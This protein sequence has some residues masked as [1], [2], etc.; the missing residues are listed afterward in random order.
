M[1]QIGNQGVWNAR[2]DLDPFAFDPWQATQVETAMMPLAQ[3]ASYQPAVEPS[4]LSDMSSQSQGTS[5]NRSDDVQFTHDL[6]AHQF[7]L[8]SPEM[9]SSPRLTTPGPPSLPDALDIA[10]IFFE[11]FHNY[12]PLFHKE[13]LLKRLREGGVDGVPRVLLLGL[14]S[15]TAKSHH[16]T[17]IKNLQEQWYTQCKEEVSR[18]M[19]ESQHALE[20]LQAAVLLIFVASVKAEF[21][22]AFIVLAE[23]WRKAVAIGYGQ[24]DGKG[25]VSMPALGS[26]SPSNWIE[27]EE[28]RR[29]A[30]L[31]FI[32]DRGLCFPIGVVHNIDD[33]RL[34]LR[35]PLV[36][37]EFQRNTQSTETAPPVQYCRTLSKLI[38]DVQQ[39]GR[40]D[41]TSLF[42]YITLAYIILGRLSEELYSLD[43]DYSGHIELLNSVSEHLVRI[44]LVTPLWATDLS[45][46]EYND[47]PSVV[48]LRVVMSVNTILVHHRPVLEGETLETSQNM[49][50]HWPHCLSAARGVANLLR[51]AARA[52]V[53][54]SAN[55]HM[56]T[57]LFTCYYVLVIEYLC[58]TS[59]RKV[60]SKTSSGRDA[61]LKADLEVLVTT[62]AKFQQS[63][64]WLGAKYRKGLLFYLSQDDDYIRRCKSNGARY[65]LSTCEHW[66][67]ELPADDI[68]IPD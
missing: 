67:A 35:F 62:F 20:T 54:F 4:N 55:A 25:K 34:A 24:I 8:P 44:A 45:A 5:V 16:S 50:A 39:S 22:V 48:W 46:A 60:S 58:P 31:L 43:F 17:H 33:R 1:I 56:A 13:S 29:V 59:G 32:Y 12:L 30:W 2:V 9:S 23:A 10:E 15:V 49:A 14:L 7:G 18:M 19:R 51:D 66:P 26:T 64:G 57:S 52:S 47:M 65:L 27:R 36:E 42:T 6:G 38:T 21:P 63:L 37:D 28:A 53:N 3:Q 41:G 68:I 40:K 61:S 11:K